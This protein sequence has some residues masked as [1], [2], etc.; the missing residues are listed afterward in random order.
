MRKKS[1]WTITVSVPSEAEEAVLDLFTSIFPVGA[2]SYVDLETNLATI[3]VYCEE[4]PRLLAAQ[5]REL[6]AGL[7]RIR[8]CG[9]DV[10]HPRLSIR[11]L[12]RQDWAESWKKHFQPIKVGSS[13][14]I[15]PSWSRL[16]DKRGQAT[17]ILDPGLSFGTGQHPTTEYCLHELV[18]RRKPGAWQAFLDI[19]TGSGILAIASARLGYQPIDALDFDPES[20][21][22][23]RA[24]ARRNRVLSRIRFSEQDVMKLPKNGPQYSVICANLISNLLISASERILARLLPKGVVIIAGILQSEFE[25]VKNAYEKA[26]LRLMRSKARKEW[27]SGTLGWRE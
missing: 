25:T 17:I 27:R 24:N 20:I 6:A 13:L 14:L 15:K 9:L 8:E 23:A 10:G 11:K 4:K 16:R 12:P 21:R 5:R 26:G 3:A 19:G 2:V 1:I 7:I 18:R 22:A